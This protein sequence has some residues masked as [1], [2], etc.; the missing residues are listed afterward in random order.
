[1]YVEALLHSTRLHSRS[2]NAQ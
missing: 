1:M 2:T